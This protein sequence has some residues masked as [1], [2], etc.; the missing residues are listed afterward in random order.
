MSLKR[1]LSAASFTLLI[2]CSLSAS[3]SINS[4][5]KPSAPIPAPSASQTVS[6]PKILKPPVKSTLNYQIETY[7]SQ[8]FGSDRTYGIVLPPGYDQQPQDQYPVIFLLHGGHGDPTA[9][10]I[11][12][13]A[14]KVIEGLYASGK[15]P[16]SIIVTPDGNDSRGTSALWDPEYING[17]YGDVVSAIGEELVQEI[18]TRYRTQSDPGF[19]A[20]G[21][22]SSGGWGA[23]N[24][25]LHHPQIFKTLFS[26]SGYFI[27]KSGT[28]NSPIEFV[29]TLDPQTRRSLAIYLDAGE[30]DGKYLDQSREFHQVLNQLEVENQFNE[31]PGGHGVKGQDVGWGFWHKHLAD[32]LT[33]VGERFRA[34]EEGRSISKR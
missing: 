15:L 18:K 10:F 1:L 28:E 31:F 13:K 5:P 19:W 8:V 3:N 33:Y 12:G 2:G 23:L 11:K 21:G 34:V 22:L 4:P 20:I 7:Q 16:P 17:R 30:G 26:H 9:W 29:K 32:S 25:G 24:V 27:D 6:Q 14:L